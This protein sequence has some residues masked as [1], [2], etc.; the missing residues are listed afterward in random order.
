[1]SSAHWSQALSRAKAARLTNSTDRVRREV[2]PIDAVHLVRDGRHLI[3]FASNNYLGLTHHPRL[4]TAMRNAL[5]TFGAGSGA[6]NLIT[7]Q[8][9][10]HAHTERRIAEWKGTEAAVLM[11]SGYTANLATIGSLAT[12]GR[13]ETK[14]VR[15]LLDKLC[16]ASLIDAV[17]ASDADYRI[18]PHNGVEKLERLL[19]ERDTDQLQV[20]V[21]ESIF[22]MDGDAAD[23]HAIASLKSR[24]EFL[25]LVDEA[26]SGGVYGQHGSGLANE[27]G[28]ADHVDITIA[29]FSKAAG[30]SGGAVCAS[31]ALCEAVVNH[32]RAMIYTTAMPP[33]IAVGI[34]TALDVMRDEPERADRVRQLAK[35]VRESL[36]IGSDPLDSPIVPIIVGEESRALEAAKQM[37]LQG[38]LVVAVR[39]PTVPRGTSRLRI[40]LS[41]E[42]SDGEVQRLIE[43]IQAVGRSK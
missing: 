33:V 16:H 25:L 38:L 8:T 19:T 27:M 29:T 22:S 39:P 32:G 15:F 2:E 24:H 23:L 7:G 10:A 9:T 21:T 42:H 17:R 4:I 41:A 31:G 20:V 34:E 43:A 30:V 26:H 40:T 37:E 3:N 18:F 6:A 28:L 11:P 36:G 1:M 35:H 5:V 12:V 14:P 13:T